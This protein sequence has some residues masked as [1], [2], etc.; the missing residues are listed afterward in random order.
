MRAKRGKKAECFR[1]KKR[2]CDGTANV[3]RRYVGSIRNRRTSGGEKKEMKRKGYKSGC[4][5][6]ECM[7]GQG[8]KPLFLPKEGERKML[9]GP[10]TL[11]RALNKGKGK[12]R[13]IV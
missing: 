10:W 8:E 11:Y 9:I 3:E 5:N 12:G 4:V 1:R 13:G 7:G 2:F 6:L